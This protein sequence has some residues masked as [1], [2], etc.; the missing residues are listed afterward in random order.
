MPRFSIALLPALLMLLP[1]S[2][3]AQNTPTWEQVTEQANKLFQE[4]KVAQAE[5]GFQQ[6][7]Y[8]AE[9]SYGPTDARVAHSMGSLG[10]AYAAQGK[11][12]EAE[13]LLRYSIVIMGKSTKDE[14][15]ELPL[16]SNL[17]SLYGAVGRFTD[18]A[19]VYKRALEVSEKVFGKENPQTASALVDLAGAYASQEK[20]GEA[21]PLATQALQIYEK[22]TGKDSPQVAAV[23]NNLGNIR[24]AQGKYEEAEALFRQALEMYQKLLG[25]DN[26]ELA[27]LM[28]NL[29]GVY[30]AMG[31]KNEAKNLVDRASK[32]RG[33]KK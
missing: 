1:L 29:G 24:A 7:L 11:V 13:A 6:A 28:E 32:I 15:E 23:L 2:S 8:I 3:L 4:G 25:P 22:T 12:L 10:T 21:E 31:K 16:L 5:Q 33:K 14:S 17:A 18:A 30:E 9:K 26:P 19:D 27:D 20:Y